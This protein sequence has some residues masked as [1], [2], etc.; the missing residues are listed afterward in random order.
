VGRSRHEKLALAVFLVLAAA[1]CDGR[2]Q[3]FSTYRHP[4]VIGPFATMDACEAFR[5]EARG[6]GTPMATCGRGR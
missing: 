3:E 5:T 4:G 6:V 1:G 2:G